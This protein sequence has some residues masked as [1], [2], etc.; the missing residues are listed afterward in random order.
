MAKISD[1][2]NHSERWGELSFK[3]RLDEA[4][5]EYNDYFLSRSGFKTPDHV[6]EQGVP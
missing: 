2:N 3:G 1:M 5:T 4:K 6:R